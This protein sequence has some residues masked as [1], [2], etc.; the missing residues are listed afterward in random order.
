M[1]KL[2]ALLLLWMPLKFLQ[3]QDSVFVTKRLYRVEAANFSVDNLGNIYVLTPGNLLKK[4]NPAGDSMAVFNDVRRFGAVSAIDVTNPLKILLYYRDFSTVVMLDRFLNRINTLDLRKLGIFQAR[5]IAL[6]YDN[7]VWVYDEQVGRLKKIGDDGKLLAETNDLRQVFDA[8]PS[9]ERIIDRDGYVYLYDTARGV[10]VFDYYGAFKTRLDLPAL[11]DVQVVNGT[12][13]ARKQDKLLTYRLGSLDL[14][15][16]GM[17]AGFASARVVR[18]T[19]LGVY[20]LS[21]D[22]IQWYAYQ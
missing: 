10:F 1:R 5:A 22:G 12:V 16:T 9:P 15:E 19:S 2:I 3:A 21:K 13:A 17:P 20:V 4:L 14:R 7:Q 6:S 8:P 18:I 11:R